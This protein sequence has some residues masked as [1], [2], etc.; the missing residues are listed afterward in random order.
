MNFRTLDLNLLRVFDAVMAE[1]SL[2]RAAQVLAMTQ[3]AVSH[4]I[5]RLHDAVG[6]ALFERTAHGM[7]PT[8]RARALWPQ[9]RGALASLQQTL[10]PAEFDPQHDAVNLR[11]AMADATAAWLLP[12]LVTAIE[13]QG[14]LANLRV[15]PLTTRDPRALL[16]QAECDLAV[17]YFPEAIAHIDAQGAD[18]SLRHQRL[19]QTRYVCVMRRGHPM[20]APG[21]LDLDAYCAAPHLLVSFS[22]RPHGFVDQAL[23]G[24]GRQRRIMLTVNQFFTAGLVVTQSDLLTVLPE[25]FVAATGFQEQLVTCDLPF[26]LGRVNIEMLWHLRRDAEPAHRWLRRLIRHDEALAPAIEDAAQ[27]NR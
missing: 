24:L 14:A 20:A 13:Q 1:G 9:V 15:L 2:T 18:A 19:S 4:A 3:P 11:L 17:G 6:E 12:P 10:A 8:A 22:G 26:E 23:A 25:S 27:T 16:E 21:A 5:K 7:K